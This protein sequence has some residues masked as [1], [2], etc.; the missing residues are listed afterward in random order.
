MVNFCLTLHPVLY[1]VLSL[2]FLVLYVEGPQAFGTV[3]L[4]VVPDYVI[5]DP[6][7]SAMRLCWF[8][9][10]RPDLTFPQAPVLDWW[11]FV[12]RRPEGLFEAVGLIEV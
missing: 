10:H 12:E 3:V 9:I 6:F 5:V 2:S 7:R 8:E 1:A 4:W 11:H